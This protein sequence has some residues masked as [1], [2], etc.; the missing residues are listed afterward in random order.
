ME[1]R[2]ANR[3]K[4]VCAAKAVAWNEGV[5]MEATSAVRNRFC[6]GAIW[7]GLDKRKG[8]LLGWLDGPLS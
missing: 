3:L 8:K 2:E 6:L 7:E 4:S 1:A 5:E